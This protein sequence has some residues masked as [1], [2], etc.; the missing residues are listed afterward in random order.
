MHKSHNDGKP[1]TLILT[2][3]AFVE[4]CKMSPGTESIF[5]TYKLQRLSENLLRISG[6]GKISITTKK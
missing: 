5:S 4:R 1:E 2:S 3:G 6:L